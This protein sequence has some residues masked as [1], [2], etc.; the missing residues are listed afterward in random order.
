MS[1]QRISSV[2]SGSGYSY[3]AG[4][5][6]NSQEIEKLIREKERLNQE[7]SQVRSDYSLNDSEKKLKMQ[8]ISTKINTISGK[9]Q[10]LAKAQGGDEVSM[11]QA[12][13]GEK[14]KL[15][16]E[17]LKLQQEIA[18][19]RRSDSMDAQEKNAE[20]IRLMTEINSIQS[21][22]RNLNI[23]DVKNEQFPPADIGI[24]TGNKE[25]KA[26]IEEKIGFYV[27]LDRESNKETGLFLSTRI[28]TLA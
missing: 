11:R 6:D 15:N 23:E 27:G 18:E 16:K 19:V 9:I 12:D 28:N 2:S 21:Q 26:E 5:A 17:K 1:V 8:T 3:S 7:L 14:Q 13:T 20:V 4:G 10:S 24:G 22:V 25:D